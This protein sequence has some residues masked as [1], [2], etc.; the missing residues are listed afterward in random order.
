MAFEEDVLDISC[1]VTADMSAYQYHFMKLSADNT[2]T[3]CT[4][5]TDSPVGVLQN[6]PTASGQVARIRVYGVSR[7]IAGGVLGF[8][9][10]VGTDAAG[11]GVVKTLDKA[12]YTGICIY[13][14]GATGMATVALFGR[15]TISAV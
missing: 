9:D 4:G 14:A 1:V 13:G 2:V 3:V 6:K 11:E 12:K 5:A 7:V 15:K 8:G 10:L